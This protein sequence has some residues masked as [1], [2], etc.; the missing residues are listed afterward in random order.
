MPVVNKLFT[1]LPPSEALAAMCAAVPVNLATERIALADALDRV[2]ARSVRADQTLP[3]FARATMDGFAV[4]AADTHGASESAPAYLELIGEVLMGTVPTLVVAPGTAARI[5]TGAMIPAGADAVVMV[6]ETNARGSQ[7]EVLTSVAAGEDV[8]AVGEDIVAGAQAVPCGRRLRPADVGALAALGYASLDVYRRPRIAILST[9][10]EVVPIEQQPQLAQVRDINSLTIAATVRRVGGDPV[11]CGIVRDD[12]RELES[13]ARAALDA[14]DALVLS[15]GS[16]VSA[17]DYTAGVVERLGS[18][19]IIAHGLAIKP[20]KPTVLAV[21]E[22]KP[23]IG[24][25]G[26][27]ASALVVAWRMLAPLVRHLGGEHVRATSDRREAILAANVASRP[28][29]ED[30]LPVHLEDR[31]GVLHATPIFGASNLI[32]TLVRADA[33]LCVPIDRSGLASGERVDVIP[34]D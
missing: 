7:I 14:A 17:R 13:R 5:H 16:S 20:G 19:G 4:R 1:V 25:P 3:A 22:G 28:G 15:A 31:A 23:V 18:P 27:P 12:E 33:L 9:G 11:L 30:Y 26:N 6:E 2:L 32:F 10:D 29:R 34:L 24:L 21:C 8:L